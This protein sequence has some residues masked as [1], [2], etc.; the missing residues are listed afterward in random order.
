MIKLNLIKM[1]SCNFYF[2]CLLSL[3]LLISY[4]TFA[5]DPVTYESAFPN[6]TFR[7][8]VEVVP[9]QDNTNRFFVVEQPGR[10]KVF[11]IN[12]NTT[13][14]KTFLNIESLVRFST[15]QEVGLLGLAFHPNYETN[16]LFYVYYTG[17]NSGN[18]NVDII[19][20]QYTVSNNDPDRANASSRVELL[21]Y[22]KNQRQSN[23]NGG[24][25]AF[26]PDGYL[27]LS[28]GDGGGGGDPQG[29][30]QNL[31]NI[32]GKILR[33]DVN[34]D[35]NNP[36]SPN[37]RYEIPS[38]NPRVGK[39]GMDILYAWGIRNTWKF[40]FDQ[41]TGRLW[42]GDVGQGSREEVNLITK[43]GNYGWNRFEGNNIY[44]SGT[45]LVT[46]PDIKPV[47]S[48]NHSNNDVSITG[49]YVYRGASNNSVLQG[50]YIFGDYVSGR[51][52]SLDYDASTGSA[53]STTLFRTDGL[54]IS[55]FALDHSGEIYFSSYGT[56]AQIYKIVGGNTQEPDVVEVD[57]VGYWNEFLDGTNGV[58][59][60][61]AVNDGKTFIAGQFTTVGEQ[62]VNNV[63]VYENETGWGSLGGGANGRVS[64]IAITDN[65]NVYVGG[66][67]TSIGGVTANNVAMWNGSQWSAL[68]AGVDGPVA[69]IEVN[70][71]NVYI[72]GAFETAGNSIAN[73]I[74]RWNGSWNAL[75]DAGTGVS[76]TNN[77]I[78]SIAF[79]ASNNLYVG[80]NFDEAGGNTANR[81][82][83]YDGNRWS[84]LGAGT[85]GFVQ[86]IT[87]TDE[88]I[89]AGGNFAIAGGNTVNRVARWNRNTSTWESISNGVSGNINSMLFS[90]NYLYVG[91]SFETVTTEDDKTYLVNN[92]ARWSEQSD[93]QAMGVGKAVGTDNRINALTFNENG[94]IYAG[95]NFSVAGNLSASNFAEWGL[96]PFTPDIN[97]VDGA[98]YEMIPQH[99]TDLRLDARGTANSSLVDGRPQDGT[100]AQKW[101]FRQISDDIYE[102]ESVDAPGKVLDVAGRRRTQNTE[103]HI[104]DRSGRSH[105]R[106]K[107]IPIGQTG[108]FR[109]QPQ[110]ALGKR[111]D[112][113]NV[114]GVPRA[115]SR[116]LDNGNSQRWR[117]IL[118]EECS[119]V[120]YINIDRNGWN[121]VGSVTVTQ[122]QEVF[123]GP[124]SEE[125]GPTRNGWSWTGPNNT[126]HG[127]REWR[128]INIQPSQAGTYTV[129]N[130]DADG[131]TASYQFSV[132]VES[133]NVPP[134]VSFESPAPNTII[135]EGDDIYVKVDASDSDGTIDYIELDINGTFVRRE[136]HNPYEWNATNQNDPLLRNLPEGIHVLKIV[137]TDNEGATTEITR[138]ITVRAAIGPN[139]PEGYTYAADERE[140]VNVE[141]TVNIAYGAN[142]QYYF[143]YNQT[144]DIGCNNNVFGDPIV[145][146][147]KNC[148][149]RP[150]S[151]SGSNFKQSTTSSI[152]ANELVIYPNPV[153]N[154][155]LQV[156]LEGDE[157]IEVFIYNMSGNQVH[158]QEVS[159]GFVSSNTLSKPGVYYIKA[160]GATGKTYTTK[161]V[162]TD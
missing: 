105:Q 130:T 84:T 72:G 13:T 21:R 127:N 29:N 114:D 32:F 108:L 31:S 79:D 96:N 25:I 148:Y 55:S 30:A 106:W 46:T 155:S 10:I 140:I 99:N 115:L 28:V 90:N 145:G 2:R 103:I 97:I 43:G 100:D 1:K 40:S 15:G 144:S 41:P 147:F 57:G 109:F 62:N 53:T 98:I 83:V 58:I 4:N 3:M 42:A 47:F 133:T 120:P 82:A 112:I 39:S 54:Y 59:D 69:K 139:G 22:T 14:Q 85:S 45:S 78:R 136:N 159:S 89:Y 135:S 104:Y 87:T 23:H 35:G 56:D 150:S 12:E 122:G 119:I 116:N 146:T 152:I 64:A 86:A 123:F 27:Y 44:D 70:N 151:T 118:Q 92:I 102:I 156:V 124:Q 160:I 71:G 143:L 52:F 11:D 129:T 63:A 80:G 137:A 81:I 157:A 19:V 60:A 37:G 128:I 5:Q 50:K 132:T 125:F 9:S 138:E 20:A 76:G 91:G 101:K 161:I 110:H 75:I 49:G 107:A 88:Y 17:T 73:N 158:H 154:Q 38:D 26:G 6:L 68:G 24:K 111:L 66:D 18:G 61:I 34:L 113:E 48:Y 51:V 67:F 149:T 94:N 33:I 117:L 7:F 162:V 65:G 134:T 16:G 121:S 93:W 8:P 74:A 141:G 126:T 131:C 153:V 142:G 95:G 77:E 36:T